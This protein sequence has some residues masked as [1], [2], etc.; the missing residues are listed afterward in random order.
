VSSAERLVGRR[1]AASAPVE[2]PGG[3]DL[4]YGGRS[5]PV[6]S[7]LAFAREGWD[8]VSGGAFLL[9]GYPLTDLGVCTHELLGRKSD[10]Q[11]ASTEGLSQGC[12]WV[13]CPNEA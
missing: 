13:V 9:Y 12:A 11:N 8:R 5:G 4:A 6:G 3:R 2:T 1:R 10:V 7:L